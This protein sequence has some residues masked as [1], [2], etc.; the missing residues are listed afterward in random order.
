MRYIIPEENNM[1]QKHKKLALAGIIA[2]GLYFISVILYLIVKTDWALTVWESMTVAG[3]FVMTAVLTAAA[4]AYQIKPMFRRFMLISLSGTLILTSAA[5]FTSIGVIRKLVSQGVSVPDYFRIG[6]FP[7]I[8]MIVDYTAW[9]LFMGCAFLAL[10]FGIQDMPI[11]GISVTC[12]SLCMVGFAGSF[13]SESLWY[14]APLGYGF[15]FLILCI[16]ILRKKEDSE[17][18]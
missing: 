13:F 7:S 3:A 4:E 2:D 17:L 6:F 10:F 18:S 5:H 11:K 8:E 14:P 16:A 9:G 15:G 12:S 1:K